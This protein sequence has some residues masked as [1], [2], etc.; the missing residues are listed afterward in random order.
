MDQAELGQQ[1][2][3]R[4]AILGIAQKTA[5]ELT[6]IS[7]HTLSNIESGKGNPS[8]RTISRVADALGLELRLDIKKM[9]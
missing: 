7:V 8:M 1:I 5:A 9:V 3:R 2:V 6:G 4:R